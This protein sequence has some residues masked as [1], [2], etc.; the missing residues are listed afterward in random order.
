MTDAEKIVKFLELRAWQV[1]ATRDM[2]KTKAERA[3]ADASVK[4]YQE[5]A[6]LVANEANWKN[7]SESAGV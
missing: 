1:G 5:A 2:K 7:I 6:L 3:A 4:A